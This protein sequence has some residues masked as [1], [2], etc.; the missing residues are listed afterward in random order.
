MQRGSKSYMSCVL[1]R[2][3]AN[4]IKVFWQT[5]ILSRPSLARYGRTGC[6]KN[7]RDSHPRV[8]LGQPRTILGH[9]RAI[10]GAISGPPGVI[11]KS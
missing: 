5:Y 3:L 10:L 8:I 9:P 2:I 7:S 1:S 4:P 6:S 11:L